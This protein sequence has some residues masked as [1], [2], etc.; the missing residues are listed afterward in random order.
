MGGRNTRAVP[1]M[2]G[3]EL[4]VRTLY[5]GTATVLAAGGA[6]ALP[7]RTGVKR[8]DKQPLPAWS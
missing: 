3:G 7:L 4:A 6:S 5:A 1:M 8:F 2:A